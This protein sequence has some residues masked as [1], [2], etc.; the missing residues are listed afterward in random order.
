MTSK[1]WFAVLTLALLAL[2]PLRVRAQA[3]VEAD[4]AYL[5]IDQVID[6]K[7]I[8]PEVDIN[9]PRYLLK[10]AVSELNG[11]TND[12]LARTGINLSELVRDVKLIRVVVIEAK[13]TNRAA[14]TKGMA[15]LRT[16]LDSKWTPVV[17]V[18]GDN[19][20]IYT[21]GDAKGESLAGLAV[22][23]QDT[24]DAVIVNIVGNV[25]LGKILQVAS[26]FDKLPKDFLQKL[27][28]VSSDPAPKPEAT[29]EKTVQ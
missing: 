5:P 7:A 23:I 19:V 26:S 28:K 18:P 15:S 4:R 12:P 9:L 1:I 24:N 21:L 27:S 11:G 3:G 13:S 8:L 25:S 6:L 10:D 16:I 22:L 17:S 2:A 14:L 20:G 29:P